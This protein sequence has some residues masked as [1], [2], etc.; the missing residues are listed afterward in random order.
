ME[1]QSKPQAKE[2]KKIFNPHTKL[3][4]KVQ[5]KKDILKAVN[6]PSSNQNVE[7]PKQIVK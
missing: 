2:F 1:S 4:S 3:N 7:N 5:G 6:N